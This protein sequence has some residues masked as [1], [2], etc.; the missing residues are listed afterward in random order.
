MAQQTLSPRDR[1]EEEQYGPDSQAA[2]DPS[3]PRGSYDP[4]RTPMG[5]P[6]DPRGDPYD[7]PGKEY[8]D[9]YSPLT[10]SRKK[11]D[12]GADREEKGRK[13]R[14]GLR[15]AEKEAGGQSGFYNPEDG[16]ATPSDLNEEEESGGFYNPGKDKKQSRARGFFRRH[17]KKIGI[18]GGIMF[19]VVGGGLAVIMLLL[20]LKVEHMVNNLESRFFS[21]AQDAVQEEASN[22]FKEYLI[23][24][25]LPGYDSCGSTIK[26]GCTARKF[27]QGPVANLYRSWADARL[28]GKLWD[29]GKGVKIEYKTLSQTWRVYGPGISKSGEDIGRDGRGLDRTFDRNSEFKGYMRQ[30]MR[31]ETKW[32]QMLLRFEVD[33]GL[34][35]G[36]FSN[37]R[38]CVVFCFLTDPFTD[39]LE[40]QRLAS[41][42]YLTNR[43]ILPRNEALGV[44]LL[45]LI[46]N[47]GPDDNHSSEDSYNGSPESD[48]DQD[49][50]AALER[51][52]ADNLSRKLSGELLDK[53]VKN[54]DDIAE[55]GFQKYLITK[56]LTPIIGNA[57]AGTASDLIPIAGWINLGSQVIRAGNGADASLKKFNY[58]VNGTVAAVSLYALYRSQADEG[59]TGH[60]T[61]TEVGSFAQSLSA[62]NHGE[63]TDP[64][65]G[66]TAG[67]EQAP[68]YGYLIEGKSASAATADNHKSSYKCNNGSTIGNG[69]LVCPEETLAGGNAITG[70]VHD[71]LNSCP[72]PVAAASVPLLC[73]KGLV[74]FANLWH[75]TFGVA[76][77]AA[78]AV[79]GKALQVAGAVCGVPVVGS[80]NPVCVLKDKAEDLIA[81]IL[82]GVVKWVI[83][84][85]FSTNMSGARTF[86]M[87]SAG[88]DVL[89]NETAHTALGGQKLTPAQSAAIVNRQQQYAREEFVKQPLFARMFNTDSQYSLVSKVAMDMPL[90]GSRA[91]AQS[92]MASLLNPFNALGRSFGSIFSTR[93]DAAVG[94]EPDPF[95]VPQYGYPDGTI[96]KDPEAYWESHCSD[97]A[98]FAYQKD[99]SWNE[100]ASGEGNADP[101]NGMPL[102][103][104][105]NPC[106]LIK[107]SIGAAGGLFD[108]NNLSEGDLS[109]VS[110]GSQTAGGT[111][112]PSATIDLQ[113]LDDSSVNVACAPNTKDLGI[114]DGYTD[115]KK[116]RI[117]ICAVSNVPSSSSESSGQYGVTGA[118]GKLVV[119]SRVSQV[120]YDMA[121]AARKAG[122]SVSA[123]S[124]F[125][126]MAHQQCLYDHTCGSNTA[127]VPGTSNHQLGVAV[128]WGP[129]MYTWLAQGNGA[130]W[131]FKALVDGEPW[132]WSPTGN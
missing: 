2:G 75:S 88:A 25:V 69:S 102:N 43:V 42:I 53:T 127:A 106:L 121:E 49:T 85:P 17:K 96:P 74:E 76:F 10:G 58:V 83:P 107:A 40:Q 20:P 98:A 16:A 61:A 72:V 78:G 99:N 67:A 48:Y 59:H 120:I 101:A 125:R 90:G 51:Y 112:Q 68:L 79:A 26:A 11:K 110:T 73:P 115:G 46:N 95:G 70:G 118:D 91:V 104:T 81:T 103:K 124:G 22:M 32:Y 35:G 54:Y 55:V 36:K 47:C 8:G 52:A 31:D 111:T 109:G 117:R 128:D 80:L 119:N 18:G 6:G 100:S 57:A 64:I 21:G 3:D 19:G 33:R 123:D 1:P 122:V 14:Q 92:S 15:E 7:R 94:A 9:D 28:E 66:G 50:H 39:K 27:G 113:H 87:M 131:G 41:K 24:R 114:A 45:C 60:E 77:D 84:A 12:K 38:Y 126:T 23:S 13:T 82:E 5:N 97:N 56:A 30:Y 4:Q 105:T 89:G 71:F 132:H 44:A 62:G 63:P 37:S 130:K 108:T 34:T 93:A 65:V 116:V 129:P 29:N 86:D